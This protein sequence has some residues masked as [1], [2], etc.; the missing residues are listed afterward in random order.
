MI[1]YQNFF[2]NMNN[3][4]SSVSKWKP[5]LRIRKAFVIFHI[6]ANLG[7]TLLF[8]QTSRSL[9]TLQYNTQSTNPIEIGVPLKY[10][11]TLYDIAAN[12]KSSGSLPVIILQQ[13]TARVLENFFFVAKTLLN[14]L[15]L[16]Q[17]YGLYIA[18][19][20]KTATIFNLVT[21]YPA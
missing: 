7:A 6:T 21:L 2:S 20:S 13:D 4:D 17:L 11:N 16:F 1:N 9:M 10:Q 18:I 3:R 14:S 12:L 8:A 19:L 5:G 15:F